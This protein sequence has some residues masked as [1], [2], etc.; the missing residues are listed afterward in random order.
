[1]ESILI[2]R[3]VG[4]LVQLF[5]VL[6]EQQV[7]LQIFVFLTLAS[8]QVLVDLDVLLEPLK[9]L[10]GLVLSSYLLVLINFIRIFNLLTTLIVDRMLKVLEFENA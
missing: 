9:S 4:R 2:Y 7:L 1:M 5:K 10:L 8:L 3:L 6:L